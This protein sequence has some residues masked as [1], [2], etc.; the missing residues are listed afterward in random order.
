MTSDKR[1][2]LL[3]KNNDKLMK[4]VYDLEV[5]KKNLEQ[6]L[7]IEEQKNNNNDLNI[8]QSEWEQSISDLK[9]AKEKYN[10]L[11]Y[12]TMEIKSILSGIKIPFYKRTLFKTL[13]KMG[14]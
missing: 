4:Q 7:K 10:T 13:R 9:T 5:E 8:L 6:R 3:R 14:R 12:K 1:I 11:N 2:E